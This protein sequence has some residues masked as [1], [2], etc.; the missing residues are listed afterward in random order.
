MCLCVTKKV[1]FKNYFGQCNKYFGIFRINLMIK[2]MKITSRLPLRPV[3]PWLSSS[4]RVPAII[5]PPTAAIIGA[6]FC[7]E[8]LKEFFLYWTFWL[9][10]LIQN[11]L[12]ECLASS[13]LLLSPPGCPES[14]LS[15]K[16]TWI[17]KSTGSISLNWTLILFLAFR[18][19]YPFQRGCFFWKIAKIWFLSMT[20]VCIRMI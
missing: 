1:P 18:E 2:M 4:L 20:Y 19:A 8:F 5:L 17:V 3:S 11:L 10:N 6:F 14:R 9:P 13:S 16:V 12:S 7:Q 15:P